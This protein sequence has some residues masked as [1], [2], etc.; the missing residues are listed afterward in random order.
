[1]DTSK[2]NFSHLLM[3]YV[4]LLAS[5]SAGAQQ[6]VLPFVNY[7]SV[8]GLIHN[9]IHVIRQDGCGY[10]WI[11]TDMG[12][13][14]FDGREFKYF[15]P[16]EPR[17]RSSR[18]ATVYKDSVIF[19]VDNFGI[20]VC[21]GNS[22]RFVKLSGPTVGSMSGV[23]KADDS[24]LYIV[25]RSAGVHEMKGLR[26]KK[27]P[28]PG[29]ERES[30]LTD[31]FADKDK[32]IWVLSS[33]GL[34]V[35]PHANMQNPVEVPFFNNH[36]LTSVNQDRH[37]DIYITSDIGLHR[38]NGGGLAAIK[39]TKPELMFVP[40]AGTL[41]SI[42]FDEK[43]IGWVSGTS[44]G[45]C[46]FDTRTKEVTDFGIPNGLISQSA[47]NVCCDKE[48]NIWVA[49]ET[50][51][52]KL[53]T[54]N[55]SNISFANHQYQ[56]IKAACNW[57]DSTLLFSNIIEMFAHR[58]NKVVK[59][60]GYSSNPGY[61]QQIF[62]KTPDG[63]LIVNREA[64]LDPGD[65]AV[66]TYVYDVA[67]NSIKNGSAVVDAAGSK[68]KIFVESGV[69]YAANDMIVNT[70]KGLMVYREGVLYPGPTYSDGRQ[71]A[72]VMC[73][74]GNSQWA[75]WVMDNNGTLV[76]YAVRRKGTEYLLDALQAIPPTKFVN[77][78]YSCMFLD[79]KDRLWLC[80]RDQGMSIVYLNKGAGATK[81]VNLGRSA[82]SSGIINDIVSDSQKNLWVA[83]AQGL[84]KVVFDKDTF[85]V[86]KDLYGSELCG[87]YIFFVKFKAGKLFVG[88]T[89]CMGTIDI[90]QPEPMMRPTVYLTGLK[91]NNKDADSLLGSHPVFEPYENTLSFVFTGIN[92]KDEKRI[93]YSYRLE[94][95]DS[96]WS[97]PSREF[98]VSYLHIAPGTYTFR[99]RALSSDGVWP[100][101]DATFTF[102]VAQPF[103]TRFWF[104][105]LCVIFISAVVY[106]VY[107]YHIRQLMVIQNIRQA[108]S[109]DLHDDIGAT[110]SS[111]NILAGMAQGGTASEARR[112]QFLDA[113]QEQSRDVAESL[114][115]IVWS[116]D[117]KNDSLELI[118]IRMQRYASDLFE[119]KKINYSFNTPASYSQGINIDMRE[120][121][122]IYLLF[123]EAVNN[124]IKYSGATEASITFDI[125]KKR[126]EMVIEDNGVGFDTSKQMS[127]NGLLNMKKRA[128][129]INAKMELISSPGKGTRVSMSLEL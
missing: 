63:R 61:L 77:N 118:F 49:T 10:I 28:V 108:I 26:T 11:G 45:L 80:G 93:K 5:Y 87:K 68:R 22:V 50:G 109:K 107:R 12:I 42:A 54:R 113:I 23:A 29:I 48:N 99:V 106:G 1:L 44:G 79:S 86:L 66:T 121:Q 33:I 31:V 24:T 34:I 51:I 40:T 96:N 97:V 73:M 27:I 129:D 59:F 78:N 74:I 101:K 84:D 95:L 124:L 56:N 14:R 2:R 21:G 57:D 36:Y 110:V 62:L 55:Y 38:Y 58:G 117:P 128:M 71:P 41:T 91:V 90:G 15:A 35:F 75:L 123:K 81:I 8:Q 102:T 115:E 114:K 25:D 88:T 17:Y 119:A 30:N 112:G 19:C 94:G 4:F 105:A 6:I 69:Y 70:D 89:G 7:N 18:Y 20:A 103:Y 125:S 47:W 98:S 39:N 111:I 32:N 67:G 122:H 126:F 60:S 64:E 65:F 127:G 43:D 53:T 116:I 104:I 82:F 3:L 85:T 13:N 9:R 46:R 52:S 16:P 83:T 72:R 37:G 100:G 92:F 76:H 120:R